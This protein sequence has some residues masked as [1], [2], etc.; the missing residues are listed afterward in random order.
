MLLRPTMERDLLGSLPVWENLKKR[1]D[2]GNNLSLLGEAASEQAETIQK[3]NL[4]ITSDQD[5][6]KRLESESQ[7]VSS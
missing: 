6:Y 3:A 2:S 5:F 1:V 4:I 7:G